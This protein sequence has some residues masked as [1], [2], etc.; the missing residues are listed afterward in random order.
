[1][2]TALIITTS[3]ALPWYYAPLCF[4][5]SRISLLRVKSFPFPANKKEPDGLC[6]LGAADRTRPLRFACVLAAL[7]PF[8]SLRRA[9]CS[10]L[11]RSFSQRSRLLKVQVLPVPSQAK[12]P[13]SGAFAWCGRQ[14]LN[15]HGFIHRNLNP[16][17]LP[18]PPRPRAVLGI[19]SR[20]DC[21]GQLSGPIFLKTK[22]PHFC[23]GPLMV[24]PPGIE[25]GLP[26]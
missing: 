6:F 26:P 25:P 19:G 9:L 1:M 22:G 23:A 5:S 2:L 10:K 8:R 7:L 14:D 13:L 20:T 21:R 12:Y 3:G 15:L 24:T 16:A 17:C 18:V 11:R 4:I